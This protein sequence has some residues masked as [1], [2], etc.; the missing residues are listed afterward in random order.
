ML[1][2]LKEKA[3]S[4]VNNASQE[5]VSAVVKGVIETIRS[6]GDAAVRQYSEKFDKW[7]PSSFKLS[8]TD[9]ENAVSAVPEQT[10]K[11]IKEVQGNIRA[12]A[13]AQRKSLQDFE[14]EIQPGVFLGQKNVPISSVGT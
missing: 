8:K 4:S 3:S 9:I 5:S 11:D 6:H 13:L 1:Q 2:Y 12:F 7:S 10:I 14:T